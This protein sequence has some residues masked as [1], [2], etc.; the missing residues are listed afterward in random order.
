MVHRNLLLP[1]NHLP[2]ELPST[3]P[4]LQPRNVLRSTVKK[5]TPHHNQQQQP[6][7]D[8]SSEND[9]IS[10]VYQWHLWSSGKKQQIEAWLNREA[11]PFRPQLGSPSPEEDVPLQSKEDVQ[12]QSK[13][14]TDVLPL[15]DQHGSIL[16]ASEVPECGESEK[17]LPHLVRA[18]PQRHRLPPVMLSY[19]TLGQLSL[20]SRH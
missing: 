18:H 4:P 17:Q 16:V 19:K 8:S 9:D 7:S 11:E 5:R 15:A 14:V 1:C 20:I 6:T 13:E 2:I 12:R 10:S 3:R